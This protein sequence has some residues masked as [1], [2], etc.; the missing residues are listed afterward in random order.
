MRK[1]NIE[2]IDDDEMDEEGGSTQA[3]LEVEPIPE[4][5][6]KLQIEPISAAKPLPVN[7]D[8]VKPSI[9]SK[10]GVPPTLGPGSSKDLQVLLN[11][12]GSQP[13][14]GQSIADMM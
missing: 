11:G 4:S 8:M 14:Q 5:S 10:L 9:A 6:S 1:L 3:P 2:P 12:I 13:S 7:A